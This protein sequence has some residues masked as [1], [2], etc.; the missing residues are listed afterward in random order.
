MNEEII[1]DVDIDEAMVSILESRYNELLAKEKLLDETTHALALQ[2]D[3]LVNE[4]ERI[5]IATH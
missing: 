2:F 3:K 5:E 4:L 1:D